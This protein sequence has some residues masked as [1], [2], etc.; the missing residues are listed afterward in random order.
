MNI[1][2]LLKAGGLAALAIALAAPPV[3]AQDGQDRQWRNRGERAA[4]H[5]QQQ[6]AQRIDRRSEG[7]AARIEQGGDRAARQAARQ[8]D[9][10]RAA[11]IDRKSER[12]AA[13]VERR[14]DARAAQVAQRRDWNRN[15]RNGRDWNRRDRDGRDG[16]EWNRNDRKYRDNR[17]WNNNARYDNRNDRKYRDSRRD[18]RQDQHRWD[19]GWRNDNRYNWSRYRAAHRSLYSPGRYYAPYRGYS[20]RSVSIGNRLNNGFFG[21]RYWINDPWRYRLPAVYGGYRW[22]R[23]YD[24][25]LLVDTHSGEVVDMIRNFFW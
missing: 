3:A 17:N 24:D 1:A 7:R 8:G 10:Q 2:K 14:G 23:Y 12:A 18:Y 21:S 22:V 11:R 25:V 16:R 9:Y 15:D 19:R 13:Q 4:E 5:Q 20:Y 6:R